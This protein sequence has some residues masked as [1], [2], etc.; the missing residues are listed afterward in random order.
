MS[1]HKNWPNLYSTKLTQ[2]LWNINIDPILLHKNWSD[3]HQH[4]AYIHNLSGFLLSRAIECMLEGPSFESILGTVAPQWSTDDNPCIRLERR[5]S[6]E[7]WAE[8]PLGFNKQ[9][10]FD[11]AASIIHC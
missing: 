7:E 11:K 5:D 4:L 8:T 2:S 9:G 6:A 3:L 1:Y 10:R